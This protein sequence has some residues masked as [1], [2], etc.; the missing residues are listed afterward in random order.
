MFF[1]RC[2]N[3]KGKLRDAIF[4]TYRIF[5]ICNY[6]E[7]VGGQKNKLQDITLILGFSAIGD[8]KTRI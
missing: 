6:I 5:A 4:G 3:A 7:A 1:L 2:K 8:T